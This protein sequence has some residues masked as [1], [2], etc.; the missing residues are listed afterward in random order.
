[1]KTPPLVSTATPSGFPSLT[2]VA[3]WG[4]VDGAPTPPPAITDTVPLMAAISSTTLA[5]AFVTY[6]SP[7]ASPV[8]A[9]EEP[10]PSML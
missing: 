4:V 7:F 9:P 8:T 1:M 5:V 10:S 6:R 3:S 2:L